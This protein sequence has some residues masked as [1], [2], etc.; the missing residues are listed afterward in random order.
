MTRAN[1]Y[2]NRALVNYYGE[3]SNGNFGKGA[4][5][6]FNIKD[7]LSSGSALTTTGSINSGDETLTLAS[8]IDFD[9][10]RGI[11]IFGAGPVATVE[12]PTNITPI[13]VGAAGSTSLTY[14]I[15][16]VDAYGGVGIAA[17]GVT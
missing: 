5:N 1:T 6:Y 12:Q 9:N 3:D 7:F 4:T 13:T 15:A 16:S 8:A 14:R 17:T 2:P 11:A 10:G